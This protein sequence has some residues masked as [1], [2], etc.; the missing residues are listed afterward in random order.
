ME[1]LSGL[2]LGTLDNGQ[3]A[4]GGHGDKGLKDR[5]IEPPWLVGLFEK[6]MKTQHN[7]S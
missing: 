2:K 5:G 7:S 4:K 1:D 3:P 6:D